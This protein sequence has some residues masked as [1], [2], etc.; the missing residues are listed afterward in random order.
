MVAW[1]MF[2]LRARIPREMSLI[3]HRFESGYYELSFSRGDR[4]V[5]LHRWALAAE[6]L[7]R[8]RLP[9]FAQRF[10][11]FTPEEWSSI[12]FYDADGV[13][14]ARRPRSGWFAWIH[15]LRAKPSHFWMRVWHLPRR[16][17]ILGVEGKGKRPLDRAMLEQICRSYETV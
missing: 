16:N 2:D 1:S 10:A 13:E 14:A 3:R 5:T 15:R 9:E 11:S 17:R 4:L 12:R 7:K 6:L 8:H